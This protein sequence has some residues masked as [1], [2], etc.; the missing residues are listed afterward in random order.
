MDLLNF[1]NAKKC[2]FEQGD[3]IINQ[4][5]EVSKLY[6]LVK[7][8]VYR[9]MTTE[10]GME[11]TLTIKNSANENNIAAL[12][13]VLV[14][15]RKPRISN[16]MFVARTSCICMEIAVDD[17]LKIASTDAELLQKIL[18]YSMEQYGS[19]IELYRS[20]QDKDTVAKLCQYLLVNMKTNRINGLKYV[21]KISNIELAKYF[22]VHAVTISRIISALKQKDIIDKKSGKIIIKNEEYLT[23]LINHEKELSYRYKKWKKL[24]RVIYNK[25]V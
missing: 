16:S 21:N 1:P 2:H 15:Y 9:Q 25:E 24:T 11:T 18:Y 14:A 7:G 23:S 19:L 8:K 22:G 17:F 10:R 5:E 20:K 6:Y 4:G 12:I 13:G 3:I